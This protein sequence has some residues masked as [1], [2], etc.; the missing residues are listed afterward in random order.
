MFAKLY[1]G[2]IFLKLDVPDANLQTKTDEDFTKCLTVNTHKG[3]YK[4]NKLLFGLKVAPANFQ[5]TI[6]TMLADCKFVILYLNDAISIRE[7]RDLYVEHVKYDF[8][9][10]RNYSFTP[11]EGEM[12]MLLPNIKYLG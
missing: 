8:E 12:R 10:I 6:D 11:S 4:Y 1:V 7:F 5:Q 3:L 2:K 9:I